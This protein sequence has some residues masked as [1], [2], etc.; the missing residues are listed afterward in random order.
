MSNQLR[1]FKPGDLAYIR[2]RVVGVAAMP[3]GGY[4]VQVSL[5]NRVGA[6]DD[7]YVHYVKED[8]LTNPSEAKR[9]TT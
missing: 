7:G 4:G 8:Q 5:V 2:V 9:G 1:N 3:N 6:V